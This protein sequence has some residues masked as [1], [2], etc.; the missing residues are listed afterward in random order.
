MTA[1]NSTS[2]NG[3]RTRP[4]AGTMPVLDFVRACYM[5]QEPIGRQEHLW[6]GSEWC[7]SLPPLEQGQRVTATSS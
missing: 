7:R 4:H 1:P 2:V 5:L 6:S 3:R